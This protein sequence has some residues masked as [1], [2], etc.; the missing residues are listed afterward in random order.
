MRELGPAPET[1]IDAGT[2]E[3]RWGSYRGEIERVDLA[4]LERG[5]LWTLARRKRWMYVCAA[6]ESLWVAAAV[7][8]LGY[9]GNA[10]VLVYDAAE[11]RMLARHTAIG[12]PGAFD[13]NDRAGEGHRSRFRAPRAAF[14]LER[15]LGT[16]AYTLHVRAPHV[17]LDARMDAR[18]APPPITA[19]AKIDGGVVDV[20]QKR[21]LLQVRGEVAVQGRQVTLDGALGGYDHTSGLL[22]R[23][24]SWKWA[25]AMGRAKTG[26]KVALNLVQGFVGEP[27]C[28]LWIDDALVPLGEGRFE[29]AKDDPLAPWRLRTADGAVDLAFSPGGLHADRTNLGVVRSRFVQPVGSYRGRV[30]LPGR[31]PIEIE[32][33]LGVTEDQDVVW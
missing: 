21:A 30:Q 22:A 32:N 11:R 29:H 10:F 23:R 3:P 14:V 19:I 5:R 26:E 18:E 25:F 2:G 4:R 13:V 31:A 27:E 20:T 7:V 9:A 12:L 17:Q 8:D 15:D 16:S 6:H 24:T 1:V 28:A 33:M